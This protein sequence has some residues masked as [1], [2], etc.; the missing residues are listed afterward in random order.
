MTKTKSRRRPA[1]VE[2]ALLATLLA[3]ALAAR[4][5]AAQGTGGMPIDEEAPL[6]DCEPGVLGPG[7]MYETRS[8]QPEGVTSA[9]LGYQCE[10]FLTDGTYVPAGYRVQVFRSCPP[11]ECA[12]PFLFAEPLPGRDGI[13]ADSYVENGTRRTVR[14]RTNPRGRLILIVTDLDAETKERERMRYVL[15]PA[16]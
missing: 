7:G 11:Q 10:E 8:S 5:A 14:L 4:P 9:I 3:T 15:D 12:F 13:Y 16:R 6:A 1:T 2:L